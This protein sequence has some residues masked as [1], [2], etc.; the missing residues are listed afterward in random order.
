M[1]QVV[2]K[3]L[4]NELD[5][6]VANMC[7]ALNDSKRLLVLYALSDGPHTVSE[8]CAVLEAPQSNTSQHLAVL[9]AAGMVDTER[10]GNSVVYSL[11]HPTLIDTI[12]QLRGIMADE[13][14]RRHSAISSR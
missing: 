2:D 11:R 5:E 1:N 6:L 9:R 8:L 13:I 4:R 12:D 7:K 3:A 10:Q 14:T